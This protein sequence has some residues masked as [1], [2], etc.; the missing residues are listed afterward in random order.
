MQAATRRNAEHEV[1]RGPNRKP[2][3]APVNY[4]AALTDAGSKPVRRDRSVAGM[5]AS[6]ERLAETRVGHAITAIRRIKSLADKTRFRWDPAQADEIEKFLLSE[7]QETMT[8]FRGGTGT[9]AVFRFSRKKTW[10][11]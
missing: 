9:K 8:A 4:H 6:F 3:A 10:P 11:E 2:E 1:R 5:E 7:V